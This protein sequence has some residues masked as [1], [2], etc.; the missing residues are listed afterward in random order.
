M[1]AVQFA[2]IEQGPGGRTFDC[3]DHSKDSCSSGH[4]VFVAFACTAIP[5]DIG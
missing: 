1:R 2:D 3:H 5:L 4:V